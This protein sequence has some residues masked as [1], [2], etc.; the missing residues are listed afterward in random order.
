MTFKEYWQLLSA[1]EKRHLAKQIESSVATLS[2][3]ANGHRNPS[4]RMQFVISMVAG[5][6]L[7]FCV[8]AA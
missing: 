3:Y 1:S 8:V 4:K 7:D 5:K 6:P 2:Q